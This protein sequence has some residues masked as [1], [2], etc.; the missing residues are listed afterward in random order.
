MFSMVTV[1]VVFNF[2]I[3]YHIQIENFDQEP[4]HVYELTL[5]LRYLVTIILRIY[6][7]MF[8]FL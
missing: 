2:T 4:E 8:Y 6:Y 5:E 7:H 3:N 1:A